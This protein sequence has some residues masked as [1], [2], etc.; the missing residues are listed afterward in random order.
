MNCGLRRAA[1]V[2]SAALIMYLIGGAMVSGQSRG[3]MRPAEQV[4]KN[5]V[6]MKGIPVDEFMATMGFF[7]AS[8]GISCLDCHTDESGSS[9]AKYAD[10]NERKR[11]TRGMIAMVNALNKNSFGGRR[12]VT[13]YTCHR[14][15]TSPEITPDLTQF[16]SLLRYRE[17]DRMID[18]FPGAPDAAEI[19]SKYLAAIGGEQKAASLTS[20]V[21]KGT[22]QTYGIPKTYEMDFYA[23]APAQRS[24]VVH[25]IAAG[26]LIDTCDGKDAW[27]AAP[28]L[29]AP[30]PLTERTGGEVD[31]LKLTAALVF[32]AQIGKL[33]QQVRVGP[34]ASFDDRDTTLI[35][36]TINGKF[37]VNLYFDDESS[38]LVRTVTY[39]DSPVGFT[40][41][42]VD[43]S[44]YREL[45]G[46]KVPYKTIVTWLDGKSV[47][48]FNE[49]R[50]NLPVDAQKFARPSTR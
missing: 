49:V 32:P 10:D 30:L 33:L 9:W 26:D 19:F 20:I 29:W 2:A 13:C 23:K 35:Q 50:A 46:V 47:L 5:V 27:V 8:L 28:A 38:L 4:F 1:V 22:Y 42:Q 39:A 11:R 7:S 24:V 41:M 45:G 14:G 18:P 48:Q 15:S 21:A 12:I 37:P 34:P 36:G 43:Y 31:A 16:Y 17:P 44:D 40:P 25:N 6:S 3:D